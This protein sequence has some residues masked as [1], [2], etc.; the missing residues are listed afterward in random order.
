MYGR[1]VLRLALACVGLAC[2]A[3][4]AAARPSLAVPLPRGN[5]TVMHQPCPMS[6]DALGCVMSSQPDTIYWNDGDRYTLEHERGHIFDRRMLDDGERNKIK[7]M[8]H[9][10]T[11]PWCDTDTY[12]ALWNQTPKNSPPCEDF[13][14]AYMNC[15]LR[16]QADDEDFEVSYG[17]NPT[18]REHRA[19]CSLIRRAS[20]TVG[21]QSS[22]LK[23]TR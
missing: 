22:E 12:M 13:A 16:I 18:R 23:P 9:K 8:L 1:R 4:T 17:Y 20:R 6:P 3:P 14:D 5:I 7:R 21:Y 10:R 19:M 2:F 15:R 11:M